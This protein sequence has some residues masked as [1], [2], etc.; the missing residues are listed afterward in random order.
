M[1]KL[2]FLS[3]PGLVKRAHSGR[4]SLKKQLASR[5]NPSAE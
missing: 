5:A 3:A 2:A 4:V 1:N